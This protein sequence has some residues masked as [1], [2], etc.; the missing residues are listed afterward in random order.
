MRRPQRGR[1]QRA[2]MRSLF[3]TKIDSKGRSKLDPT[4]NA[5]PEIS[6]RQYRRAR[7]LLERANLRP[8]SPGQFLG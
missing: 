8:G 7:S 6:R 5:K 2:E 1:V 3:D 4:E